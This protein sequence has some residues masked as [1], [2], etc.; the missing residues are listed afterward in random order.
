MLLVEIQV[1]MK[2]FLVL[3]VLVAAVVLVSADG[4]R[5]WSAKQQSHEKGE[6]LAKRFARGGKADSH[7]RGEKHTGKTAADVVG[8]HYAYPKDFPLPID[9]ATNCPIFAKSTVDWGNVE[10]YMK[11]GK[12]FNLGATETHATLSAKIPASFIDCLATYC[13]PGNTDLKCH[14]VTSIKGP[15]RVARFHEA[16]QRMIAERDKF[17]TDSEGRKPNAPP[18]HP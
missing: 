15:A 4:G 5:E 8:S 13:T 10:E 7:G 6:R 16:H 14:F 3:L 9:T 11:I 18:K 17:K 1:P 12:A 2:S